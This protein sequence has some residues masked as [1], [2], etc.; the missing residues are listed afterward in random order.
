M[1]FDEWKNREK[2]EGECGEKWH[3]LAGG[4]A[5]K[6]IEPPEQDQI[7]NITKN[8]MGGTVNLGEASLR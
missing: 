8:P 1:N 6:R 3:L 2:K 7:S 5:R 4:L